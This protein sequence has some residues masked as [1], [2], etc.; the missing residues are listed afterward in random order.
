ME[1]SKL[2]ALKEKWGGIKAKLAEKTDKIAFIKA[3]KDKQ[4]A[5]AQA[6]PTA[7]KPRNPL[8]LGTIYSEGNT[9][10]R[11]QVILFVLLVAI[12]LVSAGKLA[13]KLAGKLK[14]TAEHEQIKQDYSSELA[15]IKRKSQEKAEM[16]SLGQFTTNAYAPGEKKMMSI[17]LWVRVSDPEAAAL[18][19]RRSSEFHDK[20]MSA[21]NGLYLGKVNL[22]TENGKTQAKE[23]LKESLN[24]GMP[25]GRR[26]EEVF[27]QNLTLQ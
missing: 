3:W 13:K 7:A 20:A 25:E 23:R 19:D 18:V 12:A 5:A 11:I 9:L 22:V 24:A 4:A 15:E 10:T 1:M 27:I 8:A 26:V 6:A 16:V 21:L 17:D 2:D 14:S